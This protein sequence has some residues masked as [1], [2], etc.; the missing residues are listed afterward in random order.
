MSLKY[1]LGKLALLMVLVSANRTSEQNTLDLQLRSYTPEGMLASL[2]K[3]RKV[4]APLLLHIL[5]SG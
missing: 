4:G 1:L 3:K 5:S 2:T